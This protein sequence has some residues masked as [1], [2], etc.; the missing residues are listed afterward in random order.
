VITLSSF[1]RSSK[2]YI[3]IATVEGGIRD[4][5]DIEYPGIYV[6]LDH[7]AIWHFIES[8]IM[9]TSSSSKNTKGYFKLNNKQLFGQ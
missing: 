2:G 6:R 8:V 3:Q 5:G 7:P 9:P 1:Y 4:C